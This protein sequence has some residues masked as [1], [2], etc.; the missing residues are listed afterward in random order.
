MRLSIWTVPS[1]KHDTTRGSPNEKVYEITSI[2]NNRS[3]RIEHGVCYRETERGR[4]GEP[5]DRDSNANAA[6]T[7]GSEKHGREQI[8]L[9][10]KEN[11]L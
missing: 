8:E 4:V 7:G 11:A 2:K 9:L 10:K 5:E 6:L 3:R 1:A